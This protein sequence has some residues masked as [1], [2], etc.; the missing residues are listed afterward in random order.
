MSKSK[1]KVPVEVILFTPLY[2][3][4]YKIADAGTYRVDETHPMWPQCEAISLHEVV[5][6]FFVDTFRENGKVVY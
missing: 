6:W 3:G 5:G 4:R 2:N 1:P